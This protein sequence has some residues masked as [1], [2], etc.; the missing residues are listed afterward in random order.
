MQ[1]T[2]RHLGQHDPVGGGTNHAWALQDGRDPK[3]AP[4]GLLCPLGPWPQAFC[5]GL[6]I[7]AWDPTPGRGTSWAPASLSISRG[8]VS[9]ATRGAFGAP[10]QNRF[11][12]LWECRVSG[13]LSW[14]PKVSGIGCSGAGGRGSTLVLICR[15]PALHT[16]CLRCGVGA[17]PMMS[18]SSCVGSASE[19]AAWKP[20]EATQRPE[21]GL[22]VPFCPRA[23]RPRSSGGAG[24]EERQRVDLSVWLSP[25][26]TAA[27]AR[28]QSPHPTRTWLAKAGVRLSPDLGELVHDD[29]QRKPLHVQ[30]LRS[31]PPPPGSATAG[32]LSGAR[33]PALPIPAR[34]SRPA[35][36]DAEGQAQTQGGHL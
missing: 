6:T 13:A 18:S 24:G 15:P 10:G 30:G 9:S 12:H 3:P 16:A 7:E 14:R 1:P 36:Q 21:V 20:A 4:A 2:S 25:A 31:C 27:R 22:G 11:Q 26:P 8:C 5:G 32:S 28:L 34:R 35:R 23:R 17:R 29:V 33:A 19:R